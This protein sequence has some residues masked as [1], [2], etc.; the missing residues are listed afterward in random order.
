MTDPN[1]PIEPEVTADAANPEAEE[2]V[3]EAEVVDE[4]AADAAPKSATP[5]DGATAPGEGEA[6]GDAEVHPDTARADQLQDDYLRLQAEYV[7]Y[8][9][10]VDR[11]LPVH[12]ERAVHDLLESLLPVLDEIHLAEQHGDLPEGSP[13]RAIADKLEQVLTKQGLERVGV[14][15]EAFDP[16]VHEAL[17]HGAWDASDPELPSD[18]TAT[19]VVTVLQPGYRAGERVLRAARVAVADPQ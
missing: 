15:G 13:F 2:Q 8:K 16:N 3:V 19:T 11:D 9:R 5:A 6:T 14:K 18:A 12:K 10:R 7:N 4:D 1:Q 17:M